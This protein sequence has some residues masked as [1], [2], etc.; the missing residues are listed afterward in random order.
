[1]P[2]FYDYL[3]KILMKIMSIIMLALVCLN[4]VIMP[5]FFA[6]LLAEYRGP[7]YEF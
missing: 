6:S 4:A 7:S 3:N 2:I 5:E 1:M